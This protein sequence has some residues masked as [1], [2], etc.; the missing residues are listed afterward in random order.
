MISCSSGRRTEDRIHCRKSETPGAPQVAPLCRSRSG[1]FMPILGWRHYADPEVAPL[2]RSW[3]GSIWV[4]IN[5]PDTSARI[6]GP[7]AHS[8]GV[9]EEYQPMRP[10]N[11]IGATQIKS[12]GCATRIGGGGGNRTRVRRWFSDSVY[13]CSLPMGSRTTRPGRRGRWRASQI[14]SRSGTLR[15]RPS[16]QPA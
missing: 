10:Q 12:S 5:I 14:R 1:S 8:E 9:P 13:V 6:Q 7:S 3:I 2:C 15:R 4:I 11:K 16:S